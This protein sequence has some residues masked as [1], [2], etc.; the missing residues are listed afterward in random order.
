MSTKHYPTDLSDAEWRRLKPYVPA[1]KP[2]GRPAKYERRAI[3]NAIFSLVRSGC[4]WRMLPKDLPPWE[5][6]YFYFC[7]WTRQG[8][9]EK[10]HAI[11]RAQV[12]QKA[13]KKPQPT[14][15]ALDSQTI[16]C[17]APAGERSYDAAKKKMGRKRHAV[18]DTLGWTPWDCCGCW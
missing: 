4:S 13:G 11:L 9:W 7:Q 6:V 8:W 18:V 5:L 2:G 12:R 10:I 16:S 17:V 3:L 15:R 14:A 1:P